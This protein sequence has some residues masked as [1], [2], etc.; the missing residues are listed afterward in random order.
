[1][2]KDKEI[3]KE[4]LNFLKPTIS[5]L[6][7][8]FKNGGYP[9]STSTSGLLHLE[10]NTMYWTFSLKKLDKEEEKTCRKH[11]GLD[12]YSLCKECYS[13]TKTIKGKCS[14]CKKAKQ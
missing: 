8:V 14:E 1:M 6:K 11:V 7:F 3:K 10:K 2:T 13:M 12:G 9:C 5:L 4:V